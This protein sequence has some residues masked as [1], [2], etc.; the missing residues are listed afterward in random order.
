MLH[1]W[2]LHGRAE[3]LRVISGA[4]RRG[5]DRARGIVLA[6]EAGSGRHAWPVKPSLYA[7][8]P[9]ARGGSPEPH[10]RAP[11]HWVRSPMS[12]A[13]SAP[14]RCGGYAR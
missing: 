6:G 12:S 10:R 5:A 11:F 3:E 1:E 7:G 2:P 8:H 4:T 14:I 13:T 9:G